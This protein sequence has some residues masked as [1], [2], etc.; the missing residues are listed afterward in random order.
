M[1]QYW[2][3]VE[4]LLALAAQRKGAAARKPFTRADLRTWSD[5][6][7]KRPAGAQHALDHLERCGMIRRASE[8]LQT[9]GLIRYLVTPEGAAAAGAAADERKRQALSVAGAKASHPRPAGSFCARLWALLR[10]R[11][12]ITAPEAAATLIDAG[13]NV[14]TATNTASQY[15]RLWASAHP[16]A[17]QRSK[18]RAMHESQ[19]YVLVKDLGPTPPVATNS[20]KARGGAVA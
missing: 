5:K 8:E 20:K 3:I 7:G 14:S 4:A 12:T 10:L 18:R 17:V 19:R 15:L 1:P 6:I 16:D 11:T 9:K 2:F 13:E